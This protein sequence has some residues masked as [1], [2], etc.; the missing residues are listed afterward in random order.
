M[1]NKMNDYKQKLEEYKNNLETCEVTLEAISPI[2]IKGKE[3]D[4]GE[5]LI[6]FPDN[7]DYAY[8]IDNDALCEWLYE[9]DKQC[10]YDLIERYTK[11]FSPENQDRKSNLKTFLEQNKINKRKTLLDEL[12]SLNRQESL[13]FKGKTF[14]P[15]KQNFI[16]DGQG[17]HYIPGSSIKGAIK[18]AIAY[19]M[20]KELK[21]KNPHKFNEIVNDIK[22]RIKKHE[23]IKDSD[24]KK[25]KK[26]KNTNKTNFTK[27]CFDSLFQ[28]FFLVSPDKLFEEHPPDAA[29]TDLGKI[30]KVTDSERIDLSGRSCKSRILVIS[31]F[32]NQTK[33]KHIFHNVK[34][35]S[36]KTTFRLIIDKNLLAQYK[37]RTHLP[38]PFHDADSLRK[39]LHEFAYD[40]WNAE[41]DYYSSI[42][43]GGADI[44][45]V[46]DNFYN[47]TDIIPLEIKSLQQKECYFRLGWG[48]G[49]L[50]TTVD[51]L[52]DKDLRKNLRNKV[53]HHKP[54]NYPPPAPMSKRLVLK[55]NKPFQPLG[56]CKLTFERR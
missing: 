36:C 44:S 48:T 49:M 12:A 41:I 31:L 45:D 17:E 25:E 40:Q 51:L 38:I 22:Y 47:N 42:V 14:L 30:I 8:L 4:Y 6:K 43:N 20:L 19:K 7:D 9:K 35:F 13:V 18:T 26:K 21:T 1:N 16:T 55:D 39:I 34:T 28:E 46:R 2:H 24:F 53:I 33:S 54:I 37:E 52:F 50:G 56:W 11:Y 15:T 3:I 5:G 32:R 23:S 27:D 29:K 10:N